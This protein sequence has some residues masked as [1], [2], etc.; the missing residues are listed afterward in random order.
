MMLNIILR[1]ATDKMTKL[2]SFC[3]E[4]DCKPLKTLYQGLSTHNTLTSF[5]LRFPSIR[6]P[7][8]SVLVPPMANLRVFKALDID[9]LCY[10]DD[11]SMLMLGSKRLEDVRL[12]FSPRMRAEAESIMNL[13]TFFGR[14]H[15]ANYKLNVKHFALQNW[16]GPNVLGLEQI[17]D[18]EACSSITFLDTFGGNDPRTVFVDD[19]WK[20]VP[21]ELATSFERVRCNE[22]SPE[23]IKI[24]RKAKVS[25]KYMYLPSNMKRQRTGFTPSS[26]GS[27]G[28]PPTPSVQSLSGDGPHTPYDP[29]KDPEWIAL[30]KEYLHVIGRFHGATLKHLLL[31]DLW[32]VNQE[33]FADLVSHCTQ[34]EQLGIA[35]DNAEHDSF[36]LLMPFLPN[37]RCL[38]ILENDH[39]KHHFATYTHEQR[40]W[41]MSTELGKRPPKNLEFICLGDFCYKIG[42]PTEVMQEDGTIV[43]GREITLVDK[44]EAM[45]YEIWHLD[46][47]DISADPIAPFTN[48]K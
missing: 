4:L 1:A 48:T 43:P 3:W 34:L 21:P 41:V 15:K 44:S 45:K 47:L 39:L 20:D 32:A 2:K 17:F 46:V 28:S 35:T 23:H 14:C 30:G 6:V 33:D 19:T 11:I 10:P 18:A 24:M 9:P 40:M 27:A 7:R 38:R 8:P 13:N 25:M 42:G 37:L 12:H 36:R 22:I 16:F 29:N 26:N 31:S 5:T